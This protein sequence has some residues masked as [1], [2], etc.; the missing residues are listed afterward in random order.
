MLRAALLSTFL[1]APLT[2]LAQE[3]ASCSDAPNQMEA[4]TC[5]ANKLD[6]A[7]AELNHVY[8][9]LRSKLDA[10]GQHNLLGAQRAWM[11]F[12]DQECNLRTGFDPKNPDASGTIGPML[13]SECLADLTRQRSKEL[14]IQVKCPGGDLSCTP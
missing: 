14:Q 3:D 6:K 8:G 7:N 13:V 1:L 12:R 11:T 9:V 2:A 10:N 4:G 5:A